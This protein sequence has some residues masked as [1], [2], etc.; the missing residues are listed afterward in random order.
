MFKFV[1]VIQYNQHNNVTLI[2]TYLATWCGLLIVEDDIHLGCVK[3]I[4][5][6]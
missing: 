2:M 3:E 1:D 4:G 6:I 5:A